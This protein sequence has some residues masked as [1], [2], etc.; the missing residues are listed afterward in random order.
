MAVEDDWEEM[1]RKE[2]GSET[3]D[4]IYVVQLQW[5]WL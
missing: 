1:A 3:K 4:F 5:D 2:L